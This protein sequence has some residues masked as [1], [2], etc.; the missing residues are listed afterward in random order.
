M[1][2]RGES[3]PS[4]SLRFIGG[5]ETVG[6]EFSTTYLELIKLSVEPES[7]SVLKRSKEKA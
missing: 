5:I 3:E 6:I 4:K 7:R 2:A 1:I